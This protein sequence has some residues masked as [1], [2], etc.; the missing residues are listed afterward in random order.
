MLSP[1]LLGGWGPHYTP[2]HLYLHTLRPGTSP[3]PPPP[4][5][6]SPPPHPSLPRTFPPPPAPTCLTPLCFSHWFL[7]ADSSFFLHHTFPTLGLCMQLPVCP[8]PAPSSF[9]TFSTPSLRFPGLPWFFLLPSCPFCLYIHMD[10]TGLLHVHT[11]PHTT[12]HAPHTCL[13]FLTSYLLPP[14]HST[15]PT[16]LCLHIPRSQPAQLYY[17]SHSSCVLCSTFIHTSIPPHYHLLRSLPLLPVFLTGSLPVFSHSFTT[18]PTLPSLS[19]HL[20]LPAFSTT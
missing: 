11:V 15:L 3:T 7:P 9:F 5:L 16:C 1:C 6:F 19:S 4:I 20:P 10:S 18:F 17:P 14:A 12:H 13:Q 2:H 8:L